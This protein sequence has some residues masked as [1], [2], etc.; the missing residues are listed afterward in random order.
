MSKYYKHVYSFT[1]LSE[2][3][4]PDMN[5]LENLH[6]NLT[7][8]EDCLHSS[9]HTVEEVDEHTMSDLLRD[10]GSDP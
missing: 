7:Y 9:S 8:G 3:E 6:T 1:V 10:A 4:E 2:S 5:P